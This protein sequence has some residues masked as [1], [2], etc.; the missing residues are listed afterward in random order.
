MERGT[1]VLHRFNGDEI[2][3]IKSARMLVCKGEDGIWLWFEVDTER[4]AIQTV[5]DTAELEMRPS[6]EVAVI[7]PSLDATDL[8]GSHFSVPAGYDDQFGDYLA[9][10]YYC[11]HE[12][13]DNNEIDVLGRESNVFHVRW[14]ATT[15]DVNY[16]DG[17]KP[18]TR[19]EID[20]DFVFD[21]VHEWEKPASR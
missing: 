19:V 3:R 2:Y 1:F 8:V 20:G 10:I 11:E 17:S 18:E 16:Y 6:A 7:L 5:P 13:L 14:T 4:P 12:V 21:D 9:K 15:M